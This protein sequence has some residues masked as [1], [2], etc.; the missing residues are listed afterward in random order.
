MP[1]QNIVILLV[2]SL[3]CLICAGRTSLE[4]QVFHYVLGKVEREALEPVERGMLFEGAM[5]GMLRE[6]ADYPYS[7]YL[8]PEEE[9]EYEDEIQGK[10][11]GI[12]IFR[13]QIDEPSGELWFTPIYDSPAADALLRFGDRIVAADGTPLK[14]LSLREIGKKLRGEEG[15]RVAL[16]VRPREAIFAERAEESDAQNGSDDAETRT[17]EVVRRVFHVDIIAGD[18]RD[19]SGEWIFTLA[20]HPE[21]GYIRIDQFTETTGKE[22]ADALATIPEAKALVIDLRGNPGGFLPAAISV[23]DHF[24]PKGSEIVTTRRR[25]GSIKGRFL[26]DG[27]S[28][29]LDLK[30]ALLI[31]DGSASASEIVS[32]ALQDHDRGTVIGTRSYGKG[33]VQELFPLPCGMGLLRL[34]D[35]SFWGPSGK[36]IHRR[37]DAADTDAW[38]VHPNERFEVPMTSAEA[39]IAGLYR[40]IRAL[41]KETPDPRVTE[42]IIEQRLQTMREEDYLDDEALSEEES[43]KEESSEEN[44]AAKDSPPKRAGIAPYFDPQLERAIQFLTEPTEA[45]EPTEPTKSIEPT[46][47]NSQTE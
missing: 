6:T 9:A 4:E 19:A 11:A 23:C 31:D 28:K 8:A 16:T 18:R 30:I 12:G 15:T 40:D 46:E 26:A 47:K 37:H 41:P 1:R 35:A 17:I 20:D 44:G 32:S 38:G 45:T 24:L 34:T 5:D 33:T 27:D 14:G 10:M 22:F 2:V 21:V 7:A 29:R 13:L 36:P 3:V 42:K 39:D 43:N 25:D